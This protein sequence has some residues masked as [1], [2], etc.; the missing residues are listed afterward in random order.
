[1][2]IATAKSTEINGLIEFLRD[3]EHLLTR[4]SVYHA[5]D[6]CEETPAD[7]H[8]AIQLIRRLYEQVDLS[9][10]RVMYNCLAMHE[11]CIDPESRHLEWRPDIK[12]A[13][14]AAG[15]ET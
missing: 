10:Q 15:I 2:N 6:D 1:M 13:M 9:W 4:G 3:L 7:D 14:E 12:A 5:D 11:N 8:E